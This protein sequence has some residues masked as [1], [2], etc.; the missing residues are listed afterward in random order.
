M[1]S[2]YRQCALTDYA[3]RVLYSAIH[4]QPLTRLHDRH[5]LR[6]PCSQRPDPAHQAPKS[7]TRFF[8]AL[9]P[10]LLGVYYFD[11]FIFHPAMF[12]P[13]QSFGG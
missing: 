6:S 5:A 12:S 10:R 2:P 1:K 4:S 13:R 11:K 3:S 7:E 8:C 9:E